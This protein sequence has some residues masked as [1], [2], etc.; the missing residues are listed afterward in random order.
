M[1]VW[2]IVGRRWRSPSWGRHDDGDVAE[3]GD[4]LGPP[5]LTS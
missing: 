1:V 4:T 2:Q 3:L 5:H